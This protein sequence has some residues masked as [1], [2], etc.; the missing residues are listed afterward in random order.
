MKREKLIDY[1]GKRSQ[2]D[3]ATI[4]GV[5]QQAWN[6]WESGTATP[7]PHLMKKLE[8]DIGIPMEI[9]FADVFNNQMA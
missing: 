3:M 5:S 6:R 4:Y 2:A 1:R 8:M 7:R 9:I